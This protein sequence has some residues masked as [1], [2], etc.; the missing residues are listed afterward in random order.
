MRSRSIA[1]CSRPDAIRPPGAS[2]WNR[3]ASRSTRTA[4]SSSTQ[5]T[6]V[7]TA[8]GHALADRLFAGSAR[9]VDLD[10]VPTAIFSSPPIATVGLSQEDAIERGLI[11][12]IYKERFRPLKHRLSDRDHQTFMKLIVDRRTD[13]V[14]GCHMFGDDAPE[15]MQGFAV[16][17]T[18]GATKAMFNRTIGIHPT[19][20]EDFLTMRTPA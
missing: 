12:D 17:L 11:V 5:T 6:P 15:I 16:A 2:G 14:I 3:R 9:H 13:R 7:A 8:K 20:A 1:C 10:N 19:S 18:A 4:R